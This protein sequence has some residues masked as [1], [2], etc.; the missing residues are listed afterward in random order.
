MPK[1]LQSGQRARS[2]AE[3]CGL[4]EWG[5]SPRKGLSCRGQTWVRV[6]GPAIMGRQICWSLSH[7]LSVL[8]PHEAGPCGRMPRCL[9][10]GH[11]NK[12]GSESLGWQKLL[13]QASGLAAHQR[14]QVADWRRCFQRCF[15]RAQG[16]VSRPEGLLAPEGGGGGAGE[17]HA[18]TCKG[19]ELPSSSQTVSG[20]SLPSPLAP[21]SQAEEPGQALE[22]LRGETANPVVGEISRKRHTTS[23]GHMAAHRAAGEGHTSVACV[24]TE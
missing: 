23:A 1:S 22:S 17:E 14:P 19:L 5:W 16:T 4:L 3:E 18:G 9:P 10:P 8:P 13:T 21:H 20:V 12:A 6:P 11:R 2:G 24:G 7:D 15:C